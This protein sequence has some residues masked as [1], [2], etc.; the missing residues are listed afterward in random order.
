MRSRV[1]RLFSQS[2]KNLDAFVSLNGEAPHLDLAFFYL[3]D[4]VEGGIF[5]GNACAAFP[6][7]R[8]EILTNTLEEQSARRAKNA[9]VRVYRTRDDREAMLRKS[10]AGRKRI[11]FNGREVTHTAW[12]SLRRSLPKGARLV[13]VSGAVLKARM[14]K[15]AVEIERLQ[16]AAEIVSRV[17]D[18]IPDLLTE[19]TTEKEHA[20]EVN[21]RMQKAGAAGPSFHTIT[22]FGENAAE[23]HANPTDRKLKKG[24]FALFDFGALLQL[25]ASDITRTY[26]FGRAS[27]EQRE[28]YETVHEAQQV[29]FDSIRH[30]ATGK[31]VHSAVEAVINK[32]KYKGRF[33]H[34]TGHSIGLAVHDGGRIAAMS[35]DVL[36]TGMAFT[37]EPGIYIPGFGGVRIEDDVLVTKT[38]CKLLTTAKRELVEV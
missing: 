26:V 7:G 11:G 36:E 4:L 25:Y 18:A 5:E 8:M 15:D 6:D 32:T 33:I 31:E 3:T 19:G 2:P 27:R 34:G 9:R 10:L 1:K 24:D 37:V 12:Q 38:G 22:S 35:E 16:R 23:P 30:G 13:D 29:G 20:A 21:H 28:I 17:A 14:V